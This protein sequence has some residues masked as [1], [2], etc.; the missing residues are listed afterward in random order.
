MHCN[1]KAARRRVSRS[2]LFLV[3][4]VLRNCACVHSPGFRSKFWHHYRIRRPRFPKRVQPFGQH[5]TFSA[6]FNFTDKYVPY[7]S[8]PGLFDLMTLNM[9]HVCVSPGTVC[10]PSPQDVPYFFRFR[11]PWLLAFLFSLP[12]KWHCRRFVFVTVTNIAVQ[13]VTI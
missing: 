8:T 12:E 10:I 9:C 7:I 11:C 4:F 1:L 2:G 6:V 5:A 13:E 3:K